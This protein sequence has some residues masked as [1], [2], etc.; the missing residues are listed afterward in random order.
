[1]INSIWTNQKRDELNISTIKG[2]IFENLCHRLDKKKEVELAKMEC[3]HAVTLVT[4]LLATVFAHNLMEANSKLLWVRINF[5]ILVLCWDNNSIS[6]LS[7]DTL[8]A[9]F[10]P[11]LH[12]AQVWSAVVSLACLLNRLPSVKNLLRWSTAFERDIGWALKNANFSSVKIDGT[13]R[14]SARHRSSTTRQFVSRINLLRN[15]CMRSLNEIS[16]STLNIR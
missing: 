9:L 11:S 1:M 4:V 6:L 5:L 15:C 14:S 12:L 16:L 2:F 8:T 7:L 10:H 13:V 3:Q